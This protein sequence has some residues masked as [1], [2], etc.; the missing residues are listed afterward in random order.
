MA[1][2]VVAVGRRRT[3]AVGAYGAGVSANRLLSAFAKATADTPTP[4]WDAE[5]AALVEWF[6]KTPPPPEPFESHQ[7]VTVLRR[8]GFRPIFPG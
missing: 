5:I 8:D 2:R 4:A 3:R 1:R 6:P 7:A